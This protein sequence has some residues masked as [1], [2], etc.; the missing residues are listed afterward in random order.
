MKLVRAA[1]LR[2]VALIWL[3]KLLVTTQCTASEVLRE[4][5]SVKLQADTCKSM[6]MQQNQ[7]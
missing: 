3:G 4:I 7:G 5:G 6:F 2:L 1:A